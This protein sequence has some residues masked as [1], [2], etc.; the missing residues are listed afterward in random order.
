MISHWTEECVKKEG[1]CLKK[2]R[3]GFKMRRKRPNNI[4]FIKRS[5]PG[6]S[7]GKPHKP[8]DETLAYKN[9]GKSGE[10]ENSDLDS[11]H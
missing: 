8:E 3:G 9:G 11:A 1:Q 4:N 2:W 6:K 10:L 5:G 7:E